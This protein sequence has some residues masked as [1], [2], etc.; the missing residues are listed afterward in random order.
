MDHCPKCNKLLKASVME[1]PY[2]GIIIGKYRPHTP[3]AATSPAEPTGTY[4]TETKTSYVDTLRSLPTPLLVVI[5]LAV[6]YLANNQYTKFKTTK[7]AA[8]LSQSIF[9]AS[10]IRVYGATDPLT[11]MMAEKLKLRGIKFE[12]V[13]LGTDRDKIL[14]HPMSIRL[15][16]EGVNGNYPVVEIDGSIMTSDKLD[17]AFKKIAVSDISPDL[18][19]P[20][21]RVYG[22]VNC[23]LTTAFRQ[24][25]TAEKLPFEFIDI[26]AAENN[27]RLLAKM[28]DAGEQTG[29]I[30]LPV[31]EVNGK[32]KSS[33]SMEETKRLFQ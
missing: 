16:T 2:C 32:I 19:R 33:M 17:L 10:Q 5:A 24:A 12:L 8:Q 21:I 9:S 4:Y 3:N 31:V 28:E 15:R 1:C 30:R 23:G 25:L 6:V 7:Q 14:Q 29:S 20:Y 18:K 27:G 13:D 11:Y 22:T 26:S